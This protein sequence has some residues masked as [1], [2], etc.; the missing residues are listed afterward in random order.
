M[1]Q[2]Q[3]EK[4]KRPLLCRWLTE[5]GE[6]CGKP[7][8]SAR[9]FALHLRTQHASLSQLPPT[10]DES[11]SKTGETCGWKGCEQIVLCASITDYLLHALAHPYHSFLKSLG[12]EIQ[13]L[14][15]ASYLEVVYV[16]LGS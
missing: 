8:N 15:A 5:Q 11:C 2:L 9:T 3:Y 14:V 6:V 13:V 4:L 7:F 12:E 16:V 1:A 10:P